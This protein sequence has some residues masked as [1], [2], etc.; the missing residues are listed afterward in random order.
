MPDRGYQSATRS[1]GLSV[2]DRVGPLECSEVLARGRV[3][4][5]A[6]RILRVVVLEPGRRGRDLGGTRAR[7]KPRDSRG[8]TRAGAGGF[9]PSHIA[10]TYLLQGL[11][12]FAAFSQLAQ[13][14]PTAEGV[15]MTHVP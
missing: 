7:V 14:E 1:S 9:W 13:I 5:G 11:L 8:P 3:R 6:T 2:A 4:D 10:F 15:M 12:E